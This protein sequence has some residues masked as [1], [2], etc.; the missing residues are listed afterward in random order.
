MM[1]KTVKEV[2]K[3][4]LVTASLRRRLAVAVIPPKSLD[5]RAAPVAGRARAKS[6]GPQLEG[7]ATSVMLLMSILEQQK[8]AFR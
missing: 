4:T 2:R 1:L 6:R 3:V 5:S 7:G 8:A